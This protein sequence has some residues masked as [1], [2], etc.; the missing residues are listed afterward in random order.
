MSRQS[1]SLTLYLRWQRTRH[2]LPLNA[3]FWTFNYHL[4]SI[5]RSTRVSEGHDRQLSDEA[6]AMIRRS[7][8]PAL[9]LCAAALGPS[10]AKS[11]I[12]SQGSWSAT[13]DSYYSTGMT[14]QSGAWAGETY[15]QGM[16]M[17]DGQFYI[18]G[19]S[20]NPQGGSSGQNYGDTSNGGYGSS[21][22]GYGSSNGGY[23]SSKR[24]L[25]WRQLH[26]R[27]FHWRQLRLPDNPLARILLAVTPSRFSFDTSGPGGYGP[28]GGP[29]TWA[30]FD[31]GIT[32]ATATTGLR[33]MEIHRVTEI[34]EGTIT[35]RRQMVIIPSRSPQ[36]CI[37]SSQR[38]SD[39]P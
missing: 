13:G 16:M 5:L 22:G 35:A 4:K 33:V 17:A 29:L 10:S 2:V 24:W 38:S 21:N 32:A 9:A 39:S 8:L 19:M 15:S 31:G 26:W 18:Q 28:D 12:I 27:Q 23:G 25:H 7:Y 11:E 3:T 1:R 36:R 6:I 34:R 37:C 20:L 14:A 30:S